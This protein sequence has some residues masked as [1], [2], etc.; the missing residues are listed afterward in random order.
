MKNFIGK[1]K[2]P[3]KVDQPLP[4]LVRRLKDKSSKII[5]MHNKQLT[6]AQ[7]DVKYDVKNSKHGEKGVKMH[8]C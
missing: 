2:N 1:D 5:Y 7:K 4:K 6:D 8:S 3:V